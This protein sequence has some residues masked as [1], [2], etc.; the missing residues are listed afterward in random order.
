MTT[1]PPSNLAALLPPT[2]KEEV[3]HWIEQDMPKWDVGGLVRHAAIPSP[4]SDGGLVL[5]PQTVHPAA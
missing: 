5:I 3:V 4:S 2:W 1:S